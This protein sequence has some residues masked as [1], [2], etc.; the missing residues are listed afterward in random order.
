[1][2]SSSAP[3]KPPW[4]DVDAVLYFRETNMVLAVNP[5]R[6]ADQNHRAWRR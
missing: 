1:M 4:C 5:K 3:A 6:Q 2:N